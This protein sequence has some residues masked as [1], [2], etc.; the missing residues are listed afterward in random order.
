FGFGMDNYNDHMMVTLADKG[1]GNYQYIDDFHEARKVFTGS[2]AGLFDVVA[3]DA[4]IQVE[5]D[6]ET[7]A[8]YRLL[9]YEKRLL[10]NEDFRN[11]KIDA[12][13][14]GAGH[15]VT[16]LYELTLNPKGEGRVASVR[17]RYK[18]PDSQKVV[19]TSRT[20]RSNQVALSA[21]EGSASLRLAAS[22]AQFAE[23]LRGSPHAKD[24]KL[25]RVREQALEASRD[26]GNP[27]EAVEFAELVKKA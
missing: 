13:E 26:L 3:S 14:I 6:P 11:D 2:S 27:T 19:E 12:G 24:K 18:E 16:A 9:G 4:K 17:L 21:A 25:D 20:L 5:F 10:R 7:V 23:V 22:V 15:H 8:S 1:N